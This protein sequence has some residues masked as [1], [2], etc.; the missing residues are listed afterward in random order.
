MAQRLD[1]LGDAAK[2]RYQV[3]IAITPKRY[4]IQFEI[5]D[6]DM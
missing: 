5:C 3:T 4:E 1:L 2:S 6:C